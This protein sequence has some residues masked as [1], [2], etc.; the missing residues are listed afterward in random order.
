MKSPRKIGFFD[1]SMQVV[2]VAAG[3]AWSMVVTANGALYGW[4]CNDSNCLNIASLSRPVAGA[5]ASRDR[6]A[7]A[8]ICETATAEQR[9]LQTHSLLRLAA[10]WYILS[11]A[12]HDYPI[13]HVFS[14]L[15]LLL[16]LLSPSS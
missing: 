9:E 14:C 4:G 7:R 11:H 13:M 2:Q 1:A 10:Q 8:R 15:T 12:C 6:A 16:L 3:S 5:G